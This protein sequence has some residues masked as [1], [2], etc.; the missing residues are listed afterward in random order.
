MTREDTVR[1]LLERHGRTYAQ[2]AGIRLRDTPVPLYQLLVLTT[3]LS[4]R[5]SAGVAVRAAHEVVS[6]GMGSPRGMRASTRQHRVDALVRGHYRRYDERTATQLGD[7]AALVQERWRDDLRRLRAE[8][9]GEPG[10]IAALLQELPGI[11]PAGARIFLREVQGVWSDL[12]PYVDE[13][14]AEGARRLGLPDAPAELARCAAPED[15]PRLVAACVRAALDDHVV[16]DV[17]DGA[18]GG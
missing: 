4:A 17:R 1:V 8:A 18:A 3:L 10:A 14:A 5:I 6:S 12:M 13:R 2:E 11:G 9:R 16:A 15:L 7:G